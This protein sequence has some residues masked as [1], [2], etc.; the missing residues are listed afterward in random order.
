M[1]AGNEDPAI[2]DTIN[3]IHRDVDVIMVFPIIFREDSGEVHRSRY[4]R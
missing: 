2:G 1:I 4:I 3:T